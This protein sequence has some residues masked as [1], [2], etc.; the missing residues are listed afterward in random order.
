MT[1]LLQKAFDEIQELPE[2]EQDDL[3]NALLVTVKEKKA[4]DSLDEKEW[5]N[6]VA[7]PKGQRV[8]EELANEAKKDDCF[9]FDPANFPK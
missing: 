4:I 2:K 5:G 7:S 1:T 6:L 9:D 8:L 3:A